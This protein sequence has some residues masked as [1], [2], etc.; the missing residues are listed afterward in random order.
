MTEVGTDK[1][2]LLSEIL[3]A[4]PPVGAAMDSVTV[5]VADVPE[6]RLLGVH[7][8]PETAGSTAIDPPVPATFASV[9]SGSV[10]ITLPIGK[11]STVALLPGERVAVIVAST[12]LPIAVA[13]TPDAKHTNVPTPELQF[14]VFPAAVRTGPAAAL[15]EATSVAEYVNVHCTPAGAPEGAFKD[16]IKGSVL[17]FSVVPDARLRDET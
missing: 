2:A 13:F 3:A 1:K 5:Q 17:P 15:S 7:W 9:P 10:P 4:V 6:V 8:I 11:E 14:N 16:R 12:P